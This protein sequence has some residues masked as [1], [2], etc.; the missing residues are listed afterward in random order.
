MLRKFISCNEKKTYKIFLEH[1]RMQL[2]IESIFRTQNFT[3]HAITLFYGSWELRV[4][5]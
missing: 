4:C 1:F 2:S 5:K 3:L